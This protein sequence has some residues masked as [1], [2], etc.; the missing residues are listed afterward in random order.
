MVYVITRNE[1]LVDK[2]K[3]A[4]KT[5]TVSHAANLGEFLLLPPLE[6]GCV[7]ACVIIDLSSTTD[8]EP[9]IKF[10]K[11]SPKIGHL[12][13]IG[14]SPPAELAMLPGPLRTAFKGFIT[15]PCT[16]VEIAA[17]IGRACERPLP[18]TQEPLEEGTQ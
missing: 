5:G 7:R 1:T 17:V 14:V 13:I 12:P 16:P 11:A 8:A 9:I 6:A 18:Q 4:V 3:T 15:I 10:I 2:V